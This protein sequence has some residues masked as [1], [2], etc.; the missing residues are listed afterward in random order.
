MCVK[1]KLICSGGHFFANFYFLYFQHVYIYVFCSL[2]V[3]LLLK[4]SQLRSSHLSH[5]LIVPQLELSKKK[6][7]ALYT[8]TYKKPL[9]FEELSSSNRPTRTLRG[10]MV[11]FTGCPVNLCINWFV[12]VPGFRVVQSFQIWII[13]GRSRWRVHQRIRYQIYAVVV[14]WQRCVLSRVSN[15]IATVPVA[16]FRIVLNVAV[17]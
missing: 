12:S 2:F 14:G 8:G 17:R 9:F 15:C 10:V 16:Q 1:C 11:E 5:V 7:A 4:K 3:N 13:T 6:M